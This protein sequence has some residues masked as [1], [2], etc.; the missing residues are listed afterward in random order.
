MHLKIPNSDLIAGNRCVS[1]CGKI[2]YNS[3]ATEYE[4]EADCVHCHRELRH[5]KE[6]EENFDVKKWVGRFKSII[7]KF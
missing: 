7:V 2:V 3:E 1:K 5:E 4:L 6:Q